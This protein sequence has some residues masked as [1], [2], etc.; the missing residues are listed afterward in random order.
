[1]HLVDRAHSAIL[2]AFAHSV[3]KRET[4]KMIALLCMNTW[5]GMG[6]W[7]SHISRLCKTTCTLQHST[8]QVLV[9]F[10]GLY[11]Q[12]NRLT[13]CGGQVQL[14]QHNKEMQGHCLVDC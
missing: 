9:L 3:C 1:M 7:S 8:V 13:C 5:S 2:R 12:Y 14:L 6:E 11:Y 10:V 4:K